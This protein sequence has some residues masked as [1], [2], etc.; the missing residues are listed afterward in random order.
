MGA[1]V[2]GS[3]V[4]NIQLLF[5][6][7]V[8]TFAPAS[9]RAWQ[10]PPPR[11]TWRW[12]TW[13]WAGLPWWASRRGIAAPGSSW[14]APL[15]SF[16]ARCSSSPPSS[17]SGQ[18]GRPCLP[19]PSEAPTPSPGSSGQALAGSWA[20]SEWS[21]NVK[22]SGIYHGTLGRA[23]NWSTPLL[24]MSGGGISTPPAAPWM[25]WGGSCLLA[26]ISVTSCS[27]MDL[28]ACSS[29]ASSSSRSCYKMLLVWTEDSVL[30]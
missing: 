16:P 3:E 17:G 7:K 28:A 11:Y 14:V 30:R 18:P 5:P 6:G 22:L 26:V 23:P 12:S 24:L 2:L 19:P 29:L 27:A 4:V 21:V 10:A 15:P 25:L 8:H 1:D 9:M 20:P 13:S